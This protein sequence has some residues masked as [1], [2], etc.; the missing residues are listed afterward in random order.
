MLDPSMNMNMKGQLRGSSHEMLFPLGIAEAGCIAANQEQGCAIKGIVA[1][2]CLTI[3][4]ISNINK[5]HISFE[6]IGK[7]G[8]RFLQVYIYI[9][10]KQQSQK[11][12]Q[13]FLCTIVQHT[14][15]STFLVAISRVILTLNMCKTAKFGHRHKILHLERRFDIILRFLI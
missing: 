9:L 13:I 2:T 7:C 1:Q 6:N 4:R 14:L 15:F 5:E 8:N 3:H 12:I 10:T 11:F